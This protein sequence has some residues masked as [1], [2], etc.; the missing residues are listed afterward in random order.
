M[1]CDTG[2]FGPIELGMHWVTGAGPE[3]PGSGSPSGPIGELWLNLGGDHRAEG[4][5]RLT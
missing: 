2:L 5:S 3:P 4:G 1:R